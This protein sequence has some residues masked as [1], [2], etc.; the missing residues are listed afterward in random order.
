MTLRLKDDLLSGGTNGR[1]YV[2]SESDNVPYKVREVVTVSK[3]RRGNDSKTFIVVQYEKGSA[4]LPLDNHLGDARLSNELTAKL[5]DEDK[6]SDA[7]FR[8]IVM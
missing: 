2:D 8:Q 7:S 4:R 6:F 3:N 1:L 5:T